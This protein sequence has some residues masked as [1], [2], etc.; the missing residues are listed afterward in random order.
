M[1]EQKREGNS[2]AEEEKEEG[3]E[4]GRVVEDVKQGMGC[5]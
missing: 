1:I 3:K 4:G 2:N 5:M